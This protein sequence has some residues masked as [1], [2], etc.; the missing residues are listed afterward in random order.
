MVWIGKITGTAL[1]EPVLERIGYRNLMYI[2]AV[3]QVIGIISEWELRPNDSSTYQVYTVELAAKSW[4]VFSIGRVF[5][6]LAV[7]FVE[8]AVPGYTSEIAPAPLRGFFSGSLVFIVTL[9]NLWGTGMSRAF[10]H[11]TSRIGWMVP[12]GVQLIPP[13]MMLVLVPFTP[14]SP[15]W[16]ISHGKSKAALKSLN[17]LRS[18]EDIDNGLTLAEVEAIEMALEEQR[19]MG[20]GKWLDLVRGTYFR[21]AMVSTSPSRKECL[22]GR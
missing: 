2:C 21:R 16:L 6:Y 20:N 15:R 22:S 13:L 1:F 3:I 4:Q 10:V 9:G 11:E 19:A 7:G 18:K 12:T 14:E 17:R 8:N 5:A